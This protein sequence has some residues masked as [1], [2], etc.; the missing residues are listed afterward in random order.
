MS[1]NISSFA[2]GATLLLRDSLP[3]RPEGT[4]KTA[5]LVDEP[6]VCI[7]DHHAVVREQIGNVEFEQMAGS[8]F[9]NNN[10]ILPSLLEYVAAALRSSSAL[11]STDTMAA[12]V[13]QRYLIDA[14][15]GSGL[16]GIG[17]ADQFHKVEGVEIDKASVKWAR[18]NA[19]WNAGPGRGEVGFREGKAEILF[20][21]SAGLY[22]RFTLR[23]TD[24]CRIDRALISPPSKRQS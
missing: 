14:Y 1:R 19:A 13:E 23:I 6:H 20:D 8:F 5:E 21:V 16:F 18:K 17:L 11:S 3:P 4:R 10:S 7:T 24:S 9:Q 15:C 22:Q 2:R 12:A